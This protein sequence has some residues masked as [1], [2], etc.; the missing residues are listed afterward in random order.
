MATKTAPEMELEPEPENNGDGTR[1]RCREI[2]V[3]HAPLYRKES[4]E[5]SKQI[6]HPPCYYAAE[7]E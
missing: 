4:S 1:L 3:G 2:P 5:S 7:G 6:L